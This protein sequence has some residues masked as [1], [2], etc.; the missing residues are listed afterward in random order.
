MATLAKRGKS[1]SSTQ[2]LASK[3]ARSALASVLG[4]SERPGLFRAGLWRFLQG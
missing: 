1:W 3:E 2:W 4:N